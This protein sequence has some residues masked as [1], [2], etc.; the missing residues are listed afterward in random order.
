MVWA[1]DQDAS[2]VP[3]FG[4]F[5]GTAGRR[6]WCRPRTRWSDYVSHLA[7]ESLGIPQEELESVA[8]ERD[9]WTSLLNLLPRDA[10]KSFFASLLS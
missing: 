10:L 6:P 3:S 2:W 9:V 1:S 7:W 5:P 4:G 8:G